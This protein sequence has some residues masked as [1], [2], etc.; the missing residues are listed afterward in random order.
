MYVV[1]VGVGNVFGS[2]L[3]MMFVCIVLSVVVLV[4]FVGVVFSG[5]ILVIVCVDL[6]GY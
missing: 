4:M 2:V 1:L 6:V 5:V 3:D